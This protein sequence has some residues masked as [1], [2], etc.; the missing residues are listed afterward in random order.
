MDLK[1]LGETYG[2]DKITN[3]GYHR[4]Y[5]MHIDQHRTKRG[6][7]L[8]IGIEAG[9]SSDMWKDYF[10]NFKIY[11]ID[12]NTSFDKDRVTV[13]Q[14][15]QSN[16]EMLQQVCS[17]ISEPVW[18]IN[19]DGSHHPSH[20]ILSFSVLFEKLL[21]PGGIYII[22]DIETSYWKRGEL[23]GN[24]YKFGYKHPQSA[25][26]V[27]KHVVEDVNT[28]FL[29]PVDKVYQT[30]LL[31]RYFTPELRSMIRSITF[32]HNCIIIKKITA[33]DMEYRN[34]PYRHRDF[35]E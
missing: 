13:F 31:S 21:Q 11:G 30:K 6:A 17:S 28:R 16:P 26:E 25:I 24:N 20:Q 27:F 33:E 3:H 29:G 10:P 4:I 15:D 8:E 19:D 34:M 23:Y 1:T 35:S 14:C 2:S 5:P 9:R 12:K 7:M 32:D 22:E 18:F